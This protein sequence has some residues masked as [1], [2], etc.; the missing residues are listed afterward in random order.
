MSP[1]LQPNPATV[2]KEPLALT[3]AGSPRRR[4]A[5]GGAAALPAG[6][7][8]GRTSPSCSLAARSTAPPP[9][10]HHHHQQQQQEQQRGVRPWLT[11]WRRRSPQAPPRLPVKLSEPLSVLPAHWQPPGLLGGARTWR[12]AGPAASARPPASCGGH[13]AP[14]SPCG[15]GGWARG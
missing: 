2:G 9:W 13:R 10:Q 5:A 6:S 14:P 11:R 4:A 15:T 8:S 3:Q 12:R 1:S 7:V